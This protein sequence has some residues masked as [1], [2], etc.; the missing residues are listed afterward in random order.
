LTLANYVT[1]SR[2]ALIPLEILFLLF[3][4]NGL[5]V[6]LLI[7]LQLSDYVDGYIAHRFKQ[8]SDLG[9]FLDPLADK[10][11]AIT[12]LIALVGL[13]K[14]DSI[15]VMIIV[16]RELLVQ[17]IRISA[18]KSKIIMAASQLARWKTLILI[19]AIIML[20]LDLHY[21]GWIL[22]VAVALSLISGGAYLWKSKTLKQLKLN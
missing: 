5:A 21:A 2:I 14:A 18:A 20:I 8:V 15:P 19:I 17:G 12:V 1:L 11:L 6:I 10:V 16:A 22:W 4:L 9:K 3:G 7:L 13:N